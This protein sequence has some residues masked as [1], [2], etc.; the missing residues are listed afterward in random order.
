MGSTQFLRASAAF[1]LYDMGVCASSQF[2]H[3]L[4]AIERTIFCFVRVEDASV[5]GAL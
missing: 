4:E 1:S 3:V 5:I 2:Y